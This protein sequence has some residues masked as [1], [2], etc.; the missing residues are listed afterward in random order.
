MGICAAIFSTTMV[1]AQ[2][3]SSP[4][5]GIVKHLQAPV[6]GALVFVYGVSDST[7]TRA[8]T[9]PDGSFHVESIPAGV[10]DVI[11]YK[12][13]FYPSLVRLW[14]QATPAVSTLAIDL[15]PTLPAALRKGALDIWAWRDRLPADVLREITAESP[16]RESSHSTAA[17]RLKL[18]RAV[19]GDFSSS[20]EVGQGASNFSRTQVNF[21]GAATDTIQYGFRGSYD[22]LTGEGSSPL[23]RGSA[24]NG[25]LLIAGS[26]ESGLA[27]TYA[28]RTFESRLGGAAARL[29]REALLLNRQSERGDHFEGSFARRSETGFDR[30]TSVLGD[31]LPGNSNSYEVRGAWSRSSDDAQGGVTVE[32]W[33]RDWEKVAFLE[34]GTRSTALDASVS[35]S[36]EKNLGSLSVGGLV[37][38]RVGGS[39]GFVSPGASLR[40]QLSP[41]T[42]IL[43]AASRSISR[44]EAPVSSSP[45]A[46]S[47]ANWNAASDSQASASL[48]WGTES[49]GQLLLKATSQS[50][51]EPLRLYFDGDLFLDLGSLY[52]FDGNRLE[53][54]SAVA[55][56]RL[57][58]LFDASLSGEIG[59]VNGSVSSDTHQELAVISDRAHYYSGEAGITLRPTRTDLSCAVRR[60]RQILV[61]DAGRTDNYSDKLRI[62]LGQDLTVLGFDPF[63][64]AWKLVVSFETDTNA[65]PSDSGFEEV[66]VYRRRLMGGLAISF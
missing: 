62:S 38:G 12:T 3:A 64:T 52:L 20:A 23:S 66:A 40:I 45:R 26:P 65:L 33:R 39:G 30:A 42:S 58:T 32:V 25:S 59:R 21:Y 34:E 55:S 10:Y 28:G 36:G 44:S 22:S 61:G 43:V 37:H 17:D 54:V 49:T 60:V 27:L 47:A 9:R 53:K 8:L 56:K 63:G 13:G 7:L 11:A 35:A 29:D 19:A 15:V 2:G 41:V 48:S 14:H 51:A 24:R 16:A 18:G 46:V 50:A 31:H 6:P 1:W 5:A 57:G 4:V